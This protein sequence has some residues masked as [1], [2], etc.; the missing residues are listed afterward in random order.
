MLGQHANGLHDGRAMQQPPSQ[1]YCRG[2]CRP[3][4]CFLFCLLCP[5]GGVM[6][7]KG[8]YT[9]RN[10]TDSSQQRGSQRQFKLSLLLLDSSKGPQT[11]WMQHEQI[12][13][14]RTTCNKSLTAKGGCTAKP[15]PFASGSQPPQ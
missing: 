2:T 6:K 8:G 13:Q 9:A 1:S 7:M 3:L 15:A 10:S 11:L 14:E 5:W 12:F 4:V